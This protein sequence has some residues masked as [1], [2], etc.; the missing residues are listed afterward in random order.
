MREKTTVI[1]SPKFEP[2]NTYF[3]LSNLLSS[4]AQY[5]LLVI[6]YEI[7]KPTSTVLKPTEKYKTCVNVGVHHST[8]KHDDEVRLVYSFNKYKILQTHT[9]LT[10]HQ[11]SVYSRKTQCAISFC[12]QSLCFIFVFVTC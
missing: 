9:L 2:Y 5:Y 8:F 10:K 12:L 3:S 11:Q 4:R 1:P 7:S 6:P